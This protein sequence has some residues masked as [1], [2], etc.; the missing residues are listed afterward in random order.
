MIC[1][2]PPPSIGMIH[3][4]AFISILFT[5]HTHPSSVINYAKTGLSKQT[6]SIDAFRR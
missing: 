4:P 5:R 1:S 2:P 6:I 3:Y